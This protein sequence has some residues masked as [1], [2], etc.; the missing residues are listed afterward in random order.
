MEKPKFL[1]LPAEPTCFSQ[2]V[3]HPKWREAM[4]DEFN[5]LLF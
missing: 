3:K 1:S 5:A 4:A 2:A